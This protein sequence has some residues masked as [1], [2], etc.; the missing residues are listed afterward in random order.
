VS[1]IV[2][3]NTLLTYSSLQKLHCSWLY[4]ISGDRSNKEYRYYVAHIHILFT[5]L[6]FVD[7]DSGI[8]SS[9]S[10]TLCTFVCGPVLKENFILGVGF[11]FTFRLK[12]RLTP[13]Y[14]SPLRKA[15]RRLWAQTLRVSLLNGGAP[16]ILV[17]PHFFYLL[18]QSL[19]FTYVIGHI[20]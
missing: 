18:P 4:I 20:G 8:S 5:L 19:C 11:F 6:N 1:C 12:I 15:T 17:L 3:T 9:E 14:F 10:K 16:V 2:D 13:T 7:F